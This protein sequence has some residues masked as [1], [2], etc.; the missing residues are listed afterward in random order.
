M[1]QILLFTFL[2]SMLPLGEM[3]V[4]IPYATAN[5]ISLLNAATVSVLGA[6]IP[7]IAIIYLWEPVLSFVRK[8]LP[9]VGKIADWLLEH[10]R[11]RGQGLFQAIKYSV[12]FIFAA[13]PIP[14]LGGSWTAAVAAVAFGAPRKL[15][16][17]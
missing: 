8:L 3:R 11:K 5:G 15:S 4:S 10:S 2:L 13:I 9:F 1:I 6:M 17:L 12:V 7:G 16:V 14:F